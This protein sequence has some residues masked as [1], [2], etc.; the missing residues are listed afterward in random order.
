MFLQTKEKLSELEEWLD[1]ELAQLIENCNDYGGYIITLEDVLSY[2]TD[3][4]IVHTIDRA[5]DGDVDLLYFSKQDLIESQES[6][7]AYNKMYEDMTD[8]ISYNDTFRHAVHTYKIYGEQALNSYETM[9]V[10]QIIDLLEQ[11]QLFVV[12]EG[13]N[14]PEYRNSPLQE[15][16]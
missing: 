8:F 10:K 2:M 7:E 9:F 14:K 13:I 6:D 5:V 1:D 4:F 3:Y 12:L 11:R 15:V 16:W